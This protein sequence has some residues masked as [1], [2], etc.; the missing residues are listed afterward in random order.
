MW[1]IGFYFTHLGF[2]T[3]YRNWF[4]KVFILFRGAFIR[5]LQKFLES[6]VPSSWRSSPWHFQSLHQGPVSISTAHQRPTFF[7]L[8]LTSIS[9]PHFYKWFT[10]K[11]SELDP[12]QDSGIFTR[13]HISENLD[14][15]WQRIRRLRHSLRKSSRKAEPQSIEILEPPFSSFYNT[16]YESIQTNLL[17]RRH[18]CRRWK[19]LRPRHHAQPWLISVLK[20]MA[21]GRN[22]ILAVALRL[23]LL[24]LCM[25]ELATTVP[26][27]ST[28]I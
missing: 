26:Q 12:M 14:E 27:M 4:S 17:Y 13:Y 24:Y 22:I 21:L 5:H 3:S 9:S 20:W 25:L 18:I 7:N 11:R 8:R 15:A 2:I 28:P 10:V 16:L 6:S 23:W 1:A 19:P